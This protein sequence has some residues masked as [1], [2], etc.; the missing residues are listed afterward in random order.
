MRRIFVGLMVMVGLSAFAPEGRAQVLSN[1]PFFLYYGYF[2]P[3][4]A[5]IAATPLAQDTIRAYSAERQFTAV[6][7]R[8]GL[9]DPIQ[10]FGVS[11]LDPNAPFAGRARGGRPARQGF[12]NLNL[13][14]TGPP[15]YYNRTQ[16]YYPG[17]R[18]GRSNNANIPRGGR[19]AG[20]IN[21]GGFG[22]GF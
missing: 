4:Q 20:P 6:T 12:V 3:R 15:Q 14:G 17:L 21:R 18:T 9:Y 16:A 22:P 1:D 2:L 11:D 10:P 5:A 13:N 8:Q 19:S 7:E